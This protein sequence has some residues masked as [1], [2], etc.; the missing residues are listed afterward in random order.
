MSLVERLVDRFYD[1]YKHIWNWG[2]ISRN[3]K[4]SAVFVHE[5]PDYPW[6]PDKLCQNPNITPEFVIQHPGIKWTMQDLSLN[7]NITAQFILE[8]WPCV[9]GIPGTWDFKALS[10]AP[11]LDAMFIISNFRINWNWCDVFSCNKNAIQIFNTLIH[12][13][14]HLCDNICGNPAVTENIVKQFGFNTIVSCMNLTPEFIED[15]WCEYQFVDLD[16]YEHATP[17]IAKRLIS[18]GAIGI[19]A[20]PVVRQ[21]DIMLYNYPWYHLPYTSNPNVTQEYMLLRIDVEFDYWQIGNF[22]SVLPDLLLNEYTNI[23]D[24][25]NIH[26]PNITPDLYDGFIDRIDPEVFDFD[27]I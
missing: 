18:N 13:G 26:N 25:K 22:P 6:I 11:N 3:P 27:R 1:K 8:N 16:K 23:F 7:L 19:I 2:S 17:E 14:I 21:L 24:G 4:I 10:G 5:H 20:N 9:P 15:H 12:D